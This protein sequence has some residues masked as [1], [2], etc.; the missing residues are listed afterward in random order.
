MHIFNDSL[1]ADICNKMINVSE[2]HYQK[3]V[4]EYKN[5]KNIKY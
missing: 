5:Q 1:S 3:Y 4:V 2:F